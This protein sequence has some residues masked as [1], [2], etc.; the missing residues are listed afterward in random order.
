MNANG[1]C[2]VERDKQREA[3]RRAKGRLVK[4]RITKED[5]RYLIY[6]TFERSA[7]DGDST[8][9]PGATS[10]THTTAGGRGSVPGE[11]G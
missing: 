9:S 8:G 6:Y 10:D 1:R 7:G 5:G 11:E 2:D 3:R 4:E